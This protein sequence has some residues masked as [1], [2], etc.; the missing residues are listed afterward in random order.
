MVYTRDNPTGK[1]IYWSVSPDGSRILTLCPG[2]YSEANPIFNTRTAFV[3]E[4][5]NALEK[6]F[7]AKEPITPEGAPILVWPVPATTRSRPN[8]KTYPGE[9]LDQWEKA[10]FRRKIEFTTLSGYIDPIMPAIQSGSIRIPTFAGGTAYKFDAFWIENNEVKTRY[11]S[12][13]HALQAAEMLAAIASLH[14][15]YE[16]PVKAFHDSWILLCLN[17]D[18]NTLWGSA[19]GMVFVSDQSWDVQDRFDLVAATT[20]HSLHDAGQALLRTAKTSGCLI[21]LTGS[22]KTRWNCRSLPGQL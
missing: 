5:L 4:Q 16:Y 1:T 21:L 12:N 7:A 19:G 17:M 18:R 10:G 3:A 14:S 15:Q 8:L 11:R 6:S 9:L 2:H 20:D 22:G 13:E